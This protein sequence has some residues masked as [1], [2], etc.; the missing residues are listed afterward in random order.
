MGRTEKTIELDEIF[1]EISTRLPNVT[2]KDIVAVV[3]ETFSFLGNCLKQSKDIYIWG[4]GAFE[5]VR[6][7]HP[8]K[9][10]IPVT[11]TF[12]EIEP[13][14]RVKF[15]ISKVIRDALKEHSREKYRRWKANEDRKTRTTE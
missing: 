7:N 15:K 9:R 12:E 1:D 6:S 5:I 13:F 4:F 10:F 11:K 3:K 14:D 2:K 8:T